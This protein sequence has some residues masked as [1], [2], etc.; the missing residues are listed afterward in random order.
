MRSLREIIED[1][2]KRK[3]A[4][5]HFNIANLELLKAIA[6][7][8]LELNVPVI[9]GTS[10][11]EREFID[12]HEAAALIKSLREDHNQEIFLNAD[13]TRSLEKVKEAIDAGYDAVLFDGARLPLEENI[14]ITKK[15]VEYAKSKSTGILIEGELGYIGSSSQILEEVPEGA[16][17]K[18][19]DLTT[20]D[21]AKKFVE[22]TGVDLLAPAVGNL[23]GMF[24]DAPNPRLNIERIAEVRGV[25]VPL[26]LHGGSGI[27]D[28]DFT[29]SI[30]AGISTIHISTELRVAWR[31]GIEKELKEQ[32]KELAPYKIA[33]PVVEEL[34]KIVYNRLELFNKL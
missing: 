4:I 12:V 31:K 10:E 27:S 14:E 32:P 7:A 8:A 20:P 1:S 26:V 17:I 16:A 29:Q 28:E 3:V 25:S 34:K 18:L 13:H 11:G 30:D 23:H 33:S 19:E 22:E 9:I 15:V 24:K 21:E 5:G 6:E 2:E